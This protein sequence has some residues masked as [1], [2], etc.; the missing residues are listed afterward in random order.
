M[1][2]IF[3]SFKKTCALFIPYILQNRSARY[4]C[5]FA[6]LLIIID[7][8]AAS[9]IPYLS[10]RVVDILTLN[11]MGTLGLAIILLG[12]FWT[13]E[14]IIG[15]C[16]EIVFFPV[17]NTI[18]RNLS[19]DV[20]DHVHQIPLTEY[21]TL[22]VPEIIS[23]MKRISLS[24]RTF[25]KIF[26]LL[27]LPTIIKLCI[28]LIV[29]LKI[30]LLG[31]ILIPACILSFGSL[32]KGIQWYI[33]MREQSWQT[34]DRVTMRINDSIAN[35]K[36][37]RHFHDFE[38]KQIDQ[39]LSAEASLWYKTNT[40]L[41]LI[42]IFITLILGTTITLILFYAFQG[43]L[44]HTQ[45]SGDFI[46]IKGQLMAAF[47]PFKTLVSECRQ[48]AEAIIDIKKIIQ[49]LE[50]PKQMSATAISPHISIARTE[51]PRPNMPELM[52]NKVSFSH[53]ENRLLNQ[54]D[55]QINT[56]EKVIVL[57]KNGCGKST[58]MAIL[59][60]LHK[61][62]LGE[63]LLRGQNIETFEPNSLNKIIHFIPQD[64]RLFN[65]SLR[66]NMTYGSNSI[67]DAEIFSV[68]EKVDLLPLL[69]HLSDGLN[70]KVGDMGIRLSGG[71]KQRIA[72]GRSLLL[73]PSI[74]L[75]DETLNSLNTTSEQHLL[76]AIFASIPTVVLISH[77]PSALSFMDRAYRL[78][79]GQL[80]E[81]AISKIKKS[82]LSHAQDEIYA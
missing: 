40:R 12:L 46:F 53:A 58:L 45:T 42:H 22:S 5:I 82:P 36:I 78:H 80:I 20:V 10:K 69:K 67:S 81:I 48:L 70:T 25:I 76:Q 33:S 19:H 29:V 44:H 73:N 14:K 49:L 63:V 72:I 26:F 54:I 34:S 17:V 32:Y 62:Q 66:D 4:R 6:A 52:L 64:F 65:L 41:H 74:L 56:G 24:A 59:A 38:M 8:A 28:A 9:L 60:S 61:P 13:L 3:N 37:T 57:G 7:I 71:E 55:L 30:G 18:I 15:H 43:T 75:L 27:I 68:L 31:L 79:Q 50:I 23:C 1:E 51:H 35:T 47:L 77:R 39:L 11:I 21:Q 2:C 16:Q